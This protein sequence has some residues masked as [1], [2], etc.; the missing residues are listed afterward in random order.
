MLEPPLVK[1]TKYRRSHRH[2]DTPRGNATAASRNPMATH[3]NEGNRLCLTRLETCR[4][5]RWEI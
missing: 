3:L 5:A 4:G 2:V 1:T